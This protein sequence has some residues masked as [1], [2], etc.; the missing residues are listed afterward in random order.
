MSLDRI[1]PTART[2]LIA[3]VVAVLCGSCGR[4]PEPP[5]RPAGVPD[6]ALWVGGVD[7]GVFIRLEGVPDNASLYRA[8]IYADSSGEVLFEGPLALEPRTHPRLNLHDADAFSGWDGENLH[9]SDGA[10]L[11]VLAGKR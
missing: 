6:E 8:W 5:P 4:Q 10:K 7:G 2:V 11:R 3:I 9:L 1:C